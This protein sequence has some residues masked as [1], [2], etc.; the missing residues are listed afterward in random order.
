MD[1]QPQLLLRCFQ[2]AAT[3][4]GRALELC[5]DEAMAALQLAESGAAKLLERDEIAAAHKGL[6]RLKSAWGAQYAADLLAAFKAGSS[7]D[8]GRNSSASASLFSDFGSLGTDFSSLSL[9]DDAQV[10]QGIEFARLS[11]QLQVH[12]DAV[13]ADLDAWSARCRVSPTCGPNS[14]PCV[15]RFFP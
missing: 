6:E 3:L 2:E 9:V 5:T 7:V 14:T 11:Q 12:V 13:M 15:P 10:S 8:G 4:S 1:A